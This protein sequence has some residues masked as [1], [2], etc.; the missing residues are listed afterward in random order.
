MPFTHMKKLFFII[1]FIWFYPVLNVSGQ[2]VGSEWIFFSEL[3]P[4]S[5]SG[6]NRILPNS[7]DN[8]H[9]EWRNRIG[10]MVNSNTAL[11]IMVNYRY[12]NN[13]E[14]VT[15]LLENSYSSYSYDYTVKNNL[16]GTGAFMTRFFQINKRIQLQA[17]LYGLY[18]MGNG[19]YNMTLQGYNCPNCFT[20]GFNFGVRTGDIENMTFKE[21]NFFGGLDLGASYTLNSRIVVTTGINLVQYENYSISDGNR[22]SP[23]LSSSALYRQLDLHGSN[24][25]FAINRPI[26]HLGMMVVLS[27]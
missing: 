3:S 21:R 15:Y 16:W 14:P 25:T 5:R 11:G 18:E 13:Y 23:A 4:T 1:L 17:T 7:N 26:F 9:L 20:S 24:F 27:K 2:T 8:F 10:I 22:I 6:E 19:N 12:Y